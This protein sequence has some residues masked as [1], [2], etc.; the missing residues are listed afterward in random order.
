MRDTI[1]YD[2]YDQG[3]KRCFLCGR[4]GHGD[5]LDKHHAFPGALRGKSEQYG[6]VYWLCHTR[7]HI[8]GAD[9]VHNNKATMKW[10]QSFAQ[11]QAMIEQGWTIEQ[12]RREFGKNYLNE[13]DAIELMERGME[14]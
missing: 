12:F 13:G 6:L 5:P 14:L 1:T 11:K 4:N 3:Q 7:C 2:E 8:F 10:L 9:A